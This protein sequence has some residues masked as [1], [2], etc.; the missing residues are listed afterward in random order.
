[1]R[2]FTGGA[3]YGASK[4]GIIGSTKGA[5]VDHASSGIRI[6]AVWA[7]SDSRVVMATHWDFTEDHMRQID[8]YCAS[9]FAKA[10][11]VPLSL[12]PPMRVVV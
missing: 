9:T 7:C 4:F 10:G 11:V 2:G 6:N 1:V 3:A 5:A 8:I 12:D